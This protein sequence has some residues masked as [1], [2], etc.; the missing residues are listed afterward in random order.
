MKFQCYEKNLK[1]KKEFKTSYKTT[2]SVEQ[3]F[4]KLEFNNK[5]ASG[6]SLV[7]DKYTGKTPIEK[8]VD[9]LKYCEMEKREYKYIINNLYLL[10][11]IPL[12]YKIATEIALWNIFH[13]V[14]IKTSIDENI[15]LTSVSISLIDND[16]LSDVDKYMRWPIIKFK[17]SSLR[18]IEKIIA[19]R[20]I[21]NG[22]IWIDANGAFNLREV[23]LL[24][25]KLSHLNV[26]II[27]QPLAKGEIY[28]LNKINKFGIKLI[29]DEDC[30]NQ[31]DVYRLREYVDGVSLKI[32]K[33]KGLGNVQKMIN[34]SKDIGLSVM[35]SCKN[36]SSL[37]IYPLL[38]FANKVDFLDLDGSL[39]I[40]NDPF[41]AFKV[42]NGTILV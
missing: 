17:I 32:Y 9:F 16:F 28:K 37:S 13:D 41:E 12:S 15:L 24:F 11:D 10:T 31:E 21:Y 30:T 36:E 25:E 33:C 22:R 7:C 5:V 40:L 14:Q 38:N 3:V 39:D 20:E 6:S 1:L 23:E 26:E 18:D 27:E 8:M 29:A 2:K 34:I 42:K 4:V 19:V 35:L